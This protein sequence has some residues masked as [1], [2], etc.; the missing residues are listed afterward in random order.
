MLGIL[1]IRAQHVEIVDLCGEARCDSGL[2]LVACFRNLARGTCRIG[3]DHSLQPE[4]AD[5][6]AALAKRMHMAV[7]GLDVLDLGA[8][9]AEQLVAHR[10]E[11]LAND[12]EAGAGNKVMNVGDATRERVLDGD[13]R[14]AG[15]AFI[16]GREH[17]LERVA[18]QHRHVGKGLAAGDMRV[19]T[20]LALKGD[21]VVGVGGIRH[22][23]GLPDSAA[24]A[25]SR[26]AGVSTPSGTVST[27]A[28]S[29]VMPASSARNCSS[30]SRFSSGDGGSATKRDSAS[31]R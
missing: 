25:F 3:G 26:S 10:Q 7:H 13:H 28:T 4:F 22:H 31:R 21:D 6:T 20:G 8:L 15:V 19:R 18:G 11:V 23:A 30:F 16:H 17:V 5:H 14:E 12:I 27:S 9:E 2:R 29:I 24:R 1:D